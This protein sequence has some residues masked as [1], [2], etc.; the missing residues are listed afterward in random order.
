MTTYTHDKAS[1][2]ARCGACRGAWGCLLIGLLLLAGCEVTNTD[3]S[4]ECKTVCREMGMHL[5]HVDVGLYGHG[6]TRCRCAGDA[7]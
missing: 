2:Q 3:R 7:R 1:E 6:H 4:R 5:A